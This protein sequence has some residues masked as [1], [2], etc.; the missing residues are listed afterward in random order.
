MIRRPPKSTRTDTLFPY[1]T[2]FRSIPAKPGA[3]GELLN[4]APQLL[5]R[6]TTLTERLTPLMSA[7]NQASIAGIFDSTNRI[8][9]EL[10]NRATEV[11]ATLAEARLAARQ[12]GAATEDIGQHTGPPT[13]HLAPTHK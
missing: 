5:A 2:L 8:S 6:L 12:P 7:R 1:T 4:S 9:R 13:Q 10:A 11:S 3:L